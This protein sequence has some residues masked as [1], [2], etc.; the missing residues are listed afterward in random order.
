MFIAT[1]IKNGDGRPQILIAGSNEHVKAFL[2]DFCM[3]SD[4]HVES[5]DWGSDGYEVVIHG[6]QERFSPAGDALG[7]PVVIYVDTFHMEVS[8]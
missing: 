2:F 4:F 1:M 6:I 3:E 7:E 5:V 8:E